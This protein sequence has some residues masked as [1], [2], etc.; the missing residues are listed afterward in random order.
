MN[1]VQGN[2]VFPH[3]KVI[4]DNNVI[5]KKSKVSSVNVGQKRKFNQLSSNK[6]REVA[7]KKRQCLRQGSENRV[8]YET[9]I[10]N[11]IVVDENDN[12]IGTV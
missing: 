5:C 1:V 7:I 9:V 11:F 8:Y 10:N 6:P 12:P 4:A 2:A 3:A